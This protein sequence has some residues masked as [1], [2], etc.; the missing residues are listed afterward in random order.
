MSTAAASLSILNRLLA[1]RSVAPFDRL[2]PAELTLI[3]E[4]AEPHQAE[5]GE[6]VHAGSTPLTA[7][8]VTIDGS[9]IMADGR[10]AAALVG[11][12][13]LLTNAITPQLL[14]G[15]NGVRWMT[16]SKGYF[17]TLT[18]ECPAFVFGLLTGG[19]ASGR[20]A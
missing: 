13:A 9:L 14:A 2:S 6:T 7:L 18:R 20:D 12:P 16:I 3:A 17:F 19:P 8:W 15:P 5:P 4:I 10:T 11:V 1:L